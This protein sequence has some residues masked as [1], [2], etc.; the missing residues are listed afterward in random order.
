MKWLFLLLGLISCSS[1]F[2][3]KTPKI[4]EWEF[5][6]RHAHSTFFGDI[7]VDEAPYATV[8]PFTTIKECNN[9][10]Q[11]IIDTQPVK[12]KSSVMSDC[13]GIYGNS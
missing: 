3:V 5:D 12:Y 2:A 6:L 10:K 7:V 8:G 4:T 11:Y 9:Y 13:R 1:V